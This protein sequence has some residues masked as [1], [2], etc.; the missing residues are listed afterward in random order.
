[1]QGALGTGGNVLRPKDLTPLLIRLYCAKPKLSVFLVGKHGV[2]KSTI[3]RD[4]AMYL[5]DHPCLGSTK[6]EFVEINKLTTG[7]AKIKNE[8]GKE[9][10]ISLA[11]VFRNPNKFFLFYDLRLTELEPQD[12]MGLPRISPLYISSTESKSITTYAPPSWATLLSIPG[13]DGILFLDEITNVQR[14]DVISAAYKLF[15][16]KS[17]GNLRFSENVMVVSAGNPVPSTTEESSRYGVANPLPAP[18]LNR[19]I[20]IGVEA[21][22]IEEWREYMDKTYWDKETGKR[23]WDYTVYEFLKAYE[24]VYSWNG[25]E[26]KRTKYGIYENEPTPRSYTNL[27]LISMQLQNN[28]EQ[29]KS[30]AIGLLGSVAG[31]AFYK[32]VTETK[33]S[34]TAQ[35]ILQNPML[36]LQ[37]EYAPSVIAELAHAIA[38]MY[39][40][41]NK[42]AVINFVLTVLRNLPQ[43]QAS[44]AT[45]AKDLLITMYN[46]LTITER[47]ELRNII[48]NNGLLTIWNTLFGR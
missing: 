34:V 44:T 41:N 28:T 25:E 19:V 1:M 29:L 20:V 37:N 22:D 8:E 5:A 14:T 30:A 27:A 40:T 48:T 6:K 11:D 36:I 35:E 31:E 12:L 26:V 47:A 10:S 21:P 16:D 18:L 45:G 7:Y 24:K 23:T 43:A 33:K 15:L 2:G 3:V 9:V 39:R 32:Y 38:A 46:S 17:S 13:I 42:Q 4:V